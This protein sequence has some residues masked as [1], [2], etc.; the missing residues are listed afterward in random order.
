M[1]V[2]S[3]TVK[4]MVSRIRQVF[5]R[6]SENY[7]INLINDALVEIGMYGT[8]TEYAKISTVA[9]QMWYDISDSARD[10]DG[11]KIDLNKINISIL[12]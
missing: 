12:S 8:K 9:D 2:R 5:P 6:A 4:Q 7:I 1:S 10:S 3:I 11:R